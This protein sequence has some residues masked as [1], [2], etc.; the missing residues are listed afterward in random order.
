MTYESALH[1]FWNSFGIPAYVSS[2]VPVDVVFPYI[3][4][5]R[6]YPAPN[7]TA[8][9]VANV[10]Y[11]SESEVDINAKAREIRKGLNKQIHHDDGT[12]WLVL[13]SPAQLNLVNADNNSIKQRQINVD[14]TYNAKEI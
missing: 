6:P 4:Y 3:V 11:Y 8:S 1:S 13:G 12:T 2:A 14:Y 9:G 7:E 5:E 10:Y